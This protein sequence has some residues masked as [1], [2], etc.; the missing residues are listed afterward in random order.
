MNLIK[1]ET[2]KNAVLILAAAYKAYDNSFISSEPFLNIGNTLI[3]ERIKKKCIPKN[4][5][6]IAVNNFSNKLRELRSFD[7]CN[8]INVGST[9]GVI[10]TIK[11]AIDY[12]QEDFI[13]ICPITTIP[14]NQFTETKSIYF[15]DNKLSKE[16]WS[17]ISYFSQTKVEYLFKKKRN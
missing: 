14:D 11:K 16:N 17:A 12:I 2:E 1:I 9:L 4:N 15:G 6:Y 3:I 13:N 5:I 10:D 7:N 8:F